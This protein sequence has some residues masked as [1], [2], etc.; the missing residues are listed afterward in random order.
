MIYTVFMD[1]RSELLSSDSTSQLIKKNILLIVL[2]LGGILALLIASFQFFSQD[3]NSR[4]E[5][6]PVENEDEPDKIFVDISGAVN[7]AGVY[8]FSQDE[9]ISD[10]IEKAGG[11]TQSADRDFISKNVNQAERLVDGMKIY[12]P[13]EG[14]VVENVVLGL[15]TDPQ[16]NNNTGHINLNTATESQL[17]GLPGIGPSRA[18]DIIAGRPYDSVDDLL[19]RKIVGASVFDQIKDLVIAP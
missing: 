15:N 6:V 11:F 3:K 17:D 13:K 16:R 14:E 2:T 9:R 5:F 10:A 4:I 19:I 18:N 1:E 8:E 7:N 12:F